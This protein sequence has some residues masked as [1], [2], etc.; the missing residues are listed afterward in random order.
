MANINMYPGANLGDLELAAG[1]TS[2]TTLQDDEERTSLSII[3]SNLYAQRGR[4]MGLDARHGARGWAKLWRDGWLSLSRTRRP[5]CLRR[6]PFW[7]AVAPHKQRCD[8]SSPL[9]VTGHS[10]VADR[11]QRLHPTHR[12]L[13]LAERFL[14][15]VPTHFGGGMLGGIYGRR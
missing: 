2:A 11:A 5:T 4:V 6:G 10:T 7:V 12:I 1:S 14:Q 8:D 9:V 3:H 15:A 13:L